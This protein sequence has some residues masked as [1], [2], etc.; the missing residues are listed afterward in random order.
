MPVLAHRHSRD[1][2][3]SAPATHRCSFRA[4]AGR[5]FALHAGF[6]PKA[7]SDRSVTI[8]A[9]GLKGAAVTQVAAL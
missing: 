6:P 9:A 7:L 1:L 5:P 8:E 3:R 2:R 4:A